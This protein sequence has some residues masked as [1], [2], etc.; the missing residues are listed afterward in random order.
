MRFT[1]LQKIISSV[2]ATVMP[3]SFAACSVSNPSTTVTRSSSELAQPAESQLTNISSDS[4]NAA[5]RA[6]QSHFEQLQQEKFKIDQVDATLLNQSFPSDRPN[7]YVITLDGQS[8]SQMMTSPQLMQ[9][10]STNLISN[11]STVSLVAFG[12]AQTDWAVHF[13]LVDNN[14]IEQFQCVNEPAQNQLPWGYK[15]CL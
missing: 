14:E 15:R 12:K 4:C 10:I 7:A 3:I 11:C 8:A 6:T 13:G 9:S 5:I 1:L 2:I